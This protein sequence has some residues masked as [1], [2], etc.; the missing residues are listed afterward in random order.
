VE[1]EAALAL[2]PRYTAAWIAH[3]LA[4]ET[5]GDGKTAEASLLRAVAM[6]HTYLPCWTLANF[7]LRSGDTPQ[8]W[9]WARRAAG[10]AYDPAAL[11]QLCWRASGNAQE[12]LDRAIPPLPAVRGAYLDFL[13]RTNR[14]DAARQLAD[15]FCRTAEAPDVDRLLQYVD[16]SLAR[17]QAGPARKVWNALA[18]RR[19]IPYGEAAALT[20]GDLSVAPLERGFDWRPGRIEG[21]PISFDPGLRRMSVALSGR[22]PELCDLVEQ[23]VPLQPAAAY[24]FRFRYSTRELAAATG[25]IW[26]FVDARSGAEFATA[27]VPASPDGLR[28]QTLAFSVPPNCDLARILLRYRRPAGRMRA[29]GAAV[30]SGFWLEIS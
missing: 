24:R 26:S 3:G 29:E 2:N 6:D 10:M 22:Q 5:A 18:A 13:L 27:A 21:A 23:Y 14:M 19:L 12:I 11:F 25:L 4:A 20:N 16:A 15:A 8:F 30:F 28:E 17:K 1:L 9:T 7:Y